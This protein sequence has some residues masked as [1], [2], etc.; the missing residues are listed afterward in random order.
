VP[1]LDLGGKRVQGSRRE[2]A[3]TGASLAE[4]ARACEVNPNVLHFSAHAALCRHRCLAPISATPNPASTMLGGSGTGKVAAVLR[5]ARSRF[6]CG[7]TPGKTARWFIPTTAR[8]G[9]RLPK[10]P[11]PPRRPRPPKSER[12]ARRRYRRANGNR[13][14]SRQLVDGTWG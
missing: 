5:P 10:G 1:A 9:V 2:A 6:T 8:F 14:S 11:R 12:R 7:R 3:G 4:V 13:S